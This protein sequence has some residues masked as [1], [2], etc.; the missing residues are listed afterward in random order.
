MSEFKKG[1]VVCWISDF[2]GKKI[3]I[4][5]GV[6]VLYNTCVFVLEGNF[7]TALNISEI[8]HATP[9]EKEEFE[10]VTGEKEEPQYYNGKEV[11]TFG[12]YHELCKRAKA[13]YEG[14]KDTVSWEEFIMNYLPDS[15][16][17]FTDLNGNKRTM[18]INKKGEWRDME[19]T[20]QPE[21]Q[22]GDKVLVEARI[23]QNVAD[24]KSEIGD[25]TLELE[26]GN[27]IRIWQPVIAIHSRLEPSAEVVAESA[28]SGFS[29]STGARL[30]ECPKV[31][32]LPYPKTSG[33]APTVGFDFGE[34]GGDKSVEF[35]V[36]YAM[37]DEKVVRFSEEELQAL[38]E[39]K[40][41]AKGF[42]AALSDILCWL[43]GYK[44]GF[45]S[46][47]QYGEMGFSN[48]GIY[49]VEELRDLN[50]LLKKLMGAE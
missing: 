23:S 9:E 25:N 41:Q 12:K 13:D 28:T 37:K 5:N 35:K 50:I 48:L 26:L 34:V 45:N 47:C 15:K 36:H 43:Q 40:K 29:V 33:E 18:I 42:S 4:F 39:M 17:S 46:A 22:P 49:S 19:E 7:E 38:D 14:L 21:W 6:S 10:R 11:L 44:Q 31:E 30:N 16:I 1:D 8:R 24:S 2:T 3:G 27:G 32:G 20:K